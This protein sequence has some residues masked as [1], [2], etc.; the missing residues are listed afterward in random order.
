[1]ENIIEVLKNAIGEENVIV[2]EPM[3][4]HTTF[5]IGGNADIFVTPQSTEDIENVI[6]IAE[7][8]NTPYY[9]IGNGSNLLVKDNGISGIVIQ[10]YKKY[11]D[12][13][14]EGN[15]S[16]FIFHGKMTVFAT[17]R[18]EIIRAVTA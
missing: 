2:N 9:I 15:D 12:I 18:S 8:T 7:E 3:S 17:I 4:K 6:K 16:H 1:M 5:R 10:I 14:I 11:S 13:T